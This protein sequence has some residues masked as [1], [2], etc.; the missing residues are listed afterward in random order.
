MIRSQGR[1][2]FTITDP[3]GGSPLLT[4][5]DEGGLVFPTTLHLRR[6]RSVCRPREKGGPLTGVPPQP[7]GVPDRGRPHTTGHR[8]SLSP[9]PEVSEGLTWLVVDWSVL[10]SLVLRSSWG[11]TKSRCT[12]GSRPFPPSEL[13]HH[14]RRRGVLGFGGTRG[15]E[16]LRVTGD[17][18]SDLQ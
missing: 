13:D 16:N 8:L 12:F 10:E 2:P 7:P 1:C 6:P 14:P 17:P 3:G 5:L 18:V 11:R 4:V 15:R 9:L